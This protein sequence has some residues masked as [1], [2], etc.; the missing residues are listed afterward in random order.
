MSDPTP[1]LDRVFHALADGTRRAIVEQLVRGPQTVTDL[2]TPLG[3]SLAAIGHH[4]RTLEEGGLVR[5]SKQGR[6]RTCHI[7]AAAMTEVE[8]WIGARRADSQRRLDRLERFL[9]QRQQSESK[10]KDR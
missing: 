10:E 8:R 4:L 5:S 1:H 9:L 3:L 2:A 6:V 7:E